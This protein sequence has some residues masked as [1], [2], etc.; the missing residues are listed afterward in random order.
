MVRSCA[1]E[2]LPLKGCVP[3]KTNDIRKYKGQRRGDDVALFDS[4]VDLT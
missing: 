1:K 3:R 4:R 2:T